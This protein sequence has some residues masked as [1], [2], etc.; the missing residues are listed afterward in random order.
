M[1]LRL[2]VGLVGVAIIILLFAVAHEIGRIR[3]EHEEA[4]KIRRAIIDNERRKY[5][6]E[7]NEG[8]HLPRQR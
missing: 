5:A 8:D 3:K 7:D 6:S 4:E 2:F 1:T